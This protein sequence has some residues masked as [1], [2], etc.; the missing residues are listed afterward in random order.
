MGWTRVCDVDDVEE[1]DVIGVSVEGRDVA[2]YRDEDGEF[3][4]SDGH[5]T[6]ERMLLCDGLVMDGII[7]C[8]KHNG[9]FRITDGA[10][11]G[12]PVTIDLRTYPVRV[13]DGE[14]H[15]DLA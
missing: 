15:V 9:R 4:A 2:V 11:M 1:E 3:Y 7:E 13:E 6:H 12:A 8:P 10:A 5:C 14:V